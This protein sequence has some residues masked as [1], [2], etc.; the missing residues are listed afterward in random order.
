MWSS[1]EVVDGA[2]A[3]S[4]SYAPTSHAAPRGAGSPRW[5]VASQF[6]VAAL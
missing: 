5:S 3:N 2:I 1:S 4:A 6:V